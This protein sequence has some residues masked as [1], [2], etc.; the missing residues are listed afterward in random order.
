[1]KTKAIIAMLVAIIFT[2]GVVGLGFA[3]EVK[4]T[5]TKVE[6]NK[7]TVKDEAGKEQTVDVKDAKGVKVGD[8]VDIK[9]GVIAPAK[10]KAATGC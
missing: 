2:L 6:G 4:G 8:K 9:D 1:M 5:V 10:K 7:V 3:A